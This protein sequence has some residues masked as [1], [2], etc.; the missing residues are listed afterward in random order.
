MIN[1]LFVCMGNI[2]RSPSG[3]G[4]FRALVRDAG[5]DAEFRIDSAGTTAYHVGEAADSR[6]RKYASKRN[7][8]LTSRSRQFNRNDFDEF[9]YIL[10]MDYSNYQDIKRLD[11]NSE[12][13]DKIFMMNDFSKANKGAD[14]P[15]PYY[16]GEAGFELVLDML[17]ESCSGLLSELRARHN[18]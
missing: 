8:Q 3:E 14:V 12:Y 15:D 6:M 5:L 17:D 11:R 4:V 13:D 18:V 9:D 1:V 7:I 2:C 10:A 16:G